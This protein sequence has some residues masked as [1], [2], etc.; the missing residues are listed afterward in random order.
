[1]RKKQFFEE[2]ESKTIELKSAL[3]KFEALIKT[4]IAFANGVG[5][6]I[7]IDVED[8]TLKTYP[9]SFLASVCIEIHT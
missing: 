7:V 4:C 1:M 6:S 9:P 5:G 8:T 2:R 3:P